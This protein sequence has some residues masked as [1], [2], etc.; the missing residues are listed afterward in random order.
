MSEP[1]VDAPPT[2]PVA[3]P[4]ATLPEDSPLGR[5]LDIVDRVVEVGRRQTKKVERAAAVTRRL[6]GL[7]F[8]VVVALG[9]VVL[10]VLA[11]LRGAVEL[12]DLIF[13]GQ[14]AWF[15]WLVLG[16]I[17]LLIA[18]FVGTVRNK[19]GPGD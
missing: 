12:T 9:G 2:L 19:G 17:F 10:L 4:P 14:R 1:T 16:G 5:V 15:A 3:A 11:A 7:L 13:D 8:G 18:L 6:P